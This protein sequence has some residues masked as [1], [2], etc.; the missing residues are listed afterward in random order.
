MVIEATEAIVVPQPYELTFQSVKL[1]PLGRE[2]V[3]VKTRYTSISAGTERMLLAG[4]LV[5]MAG[6]PFPCIPGYETVGEIIEV[7]PEVPEGFLGELVF[8]GGSYGY[9]GVTSAWGGQSRYIS[10][11][12]HK[13][14]R[15]DGLNP[16]EAVA[17]APA[18]TAWHGVEL[19][20]PQAG[21]VV[22]VL[23]QGPIGQF[24]AQ[25]AKLRGATV[26]VA[27][28][29]PARLER[30]TAG[31]YKID[32]SRQSLKDGLPAKIDVFIDATGKMAAINACLMQMQTRGRVLLLGFY[33]RIELDFA[34]PFIK[35]LSFRPSREWAA[36]D[37]PAVIQAFQAHRLQATHL[38]T[39]RFPISEYQASYK[40]ALENPDCLKVL[41]EW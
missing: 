39:H 9:E 29:V 13:A 35:E 8:I 27:D 19:I 6:L 3:L 25:S 7:G 11:D 31:D 37:I 20:A 32:L 16:A 15:L 30:A 38:F 2:E 23:G 34:I 40:A 33:Q 5:E 41:M 22:L 21:E 12:Y 18:A 17:I 26:V 4:Q 36:E 28:V 24:A 14:F 10:A 1:R